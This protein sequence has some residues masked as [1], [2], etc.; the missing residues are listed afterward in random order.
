M[1]APLRARWNFHFVSKVIHGIAWRTFLARPVVRTCACSHWR[2]LREGDYIS[3][4]A[5]MKHGY[6]VAPGKT[7]LLISM[8]AP[9]YDP[10]KRVRTIEHERG[11]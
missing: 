8:D 2:L 7:A 10:Q 9:P 3:I 1:E 6:S 11:K 4:P 5:G